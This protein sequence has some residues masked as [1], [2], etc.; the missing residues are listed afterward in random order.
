MRPFLLAGSALLALFAPVGAAS[1]TDVTYINSSPAVDG[2]MVTTGFVQGD[3]LVN[4]DGLFNGLLQNDGN[5]VV[6]YGTYPYTSPSEYSGPLATT[7]AARGR[8]ASA[9]IEAMINCL[10]PVLRAFMFTKTII[11]PL[12]SLN[13]RVLTTTMRQRF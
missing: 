8:M 13:S 11:Q 12:R 5:F 7:I 4:P 2:Q 9:L 10:T 6:S 1:A 3:V